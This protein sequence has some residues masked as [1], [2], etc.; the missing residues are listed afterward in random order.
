MKKYLSN[1]HKI[2][3][4]HLQ[5]VDNHYAKFEYKVM[6]TVWVTDY[7][8][9]TPPKELGWKKISKFKPV[10][11]EKIFIQCAQNGRCIVY[12]KPLNGYFEKQ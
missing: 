5:C 9:Q 10:K 6:K 12:S 11:N 4:A 8:N 1:A 7:T 3:R 2:G